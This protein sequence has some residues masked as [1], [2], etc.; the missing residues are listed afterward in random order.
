MN[1]I[2]KLKK[3]GFAASLAFLS[4]QGPWSFWPEDPDN[5]RGIWVY[6]HIV[7]GRPVS[8]VCLEKLLDLDEIY[9]PTSAFFK[10]AELI[11]SG[12]FSG[13]DEII[14]LVQNPAKPN[15]F[16]GPNDLY[17]EIGKAYKLE[18]TVRWDS[19]GHFVTSKFNAETSIPKEF[20]IKHALA[21]V[22]GIF[23][24]YNKGGNIYYLEPPNDLLSHYYI[25]KYSPDVA[26]VLVTIVYDPSEVSWGLNT[27]DLLFSQ[28][29][30]ISNKAMFGGRHRLDY[31]W[32]QRYGDDRVNNAIDSIPMIN[33]SF[34]IGKDIK[35]LFYATGM[36]YREYV[37]SDTY[38]ASDSRIKAKYN[39]NGGAGFFAGMLVDTFT[40][41]VFMPEGGTIYSNN[42][43]RTAY[44]EKKNWETKECRL[45][46]NGD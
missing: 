28:E 27:F 23:E 25:P 10:S 22:N 37:S 11:I 8:D 40:V 19:S 39:I 43:A 36:E 3:V 4:C 14:E 20:Y 42:E 16:D 30:D 18:A 7:S 41:N 32:N 12:P 35:Y 21:P 33:T 45:W 26:G 9:E 34:P 2:F 6:A 46:Q 29:V 38:A 13:N 44:C 1:I 24:E 15:C 31:I 5:Y 17:A